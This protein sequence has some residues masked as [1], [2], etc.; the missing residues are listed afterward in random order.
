MSQQKYEFVRKYVEEEL[1]NQN[2]PCSLTYYTFLL[3]TYAHKVYRQLLTPKNGTS[4]ICTI[5]NFCTL[6]I[7]N[8]IILKSNEASS[9][10][11]IHQLPHLSRF[12]K[13]Y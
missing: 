12:Q 11:P 4:C 5:S 13:I 1:K 3:L 9:S 6:N 7:R 2:E 8:E 10:I